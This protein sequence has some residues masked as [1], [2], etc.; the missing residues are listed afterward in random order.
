MNI[1]LAANMPRVTT[2]KYPKY[3]SFVY[4]TCCNIQNFL[5]TFIGG[6]IVI[7]DLLSNEEGYE[8]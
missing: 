4:K 6:K 1:I 5:Q 2:N 7:T 3:T 8:I